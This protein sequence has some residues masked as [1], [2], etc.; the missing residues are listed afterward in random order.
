MKIKRS[1]GVLAIFSIALVGC[2]GKEENSTEKQQEI[3][4]TVDQEM[5]TMNSVLA[6]DTY[7]IT[8]LNNVMEGLYRLTAEN[9][10]ELAGAKELPEI[11]ENQLIYKIE[12]NDQAKWSNGEPVTAEDYVYAW[13]KAVAPETAAEYSYLF[14][15]IE[16]ADDIIAGKKDSTTLGITAVDDENIEITLVKP[17]PYFSHLLAFPAFFPQN[18]KFVSEQGENYAKSSEHLIYNGPF[19]L[20]DFDGPGTDT[21]WTYLKNDHYW[22]KEKVQ[23]TKIKNQV[24]KES[25]T[26]VNL[27]EAKQVDD[28]LLTGELA[29]QYQASPEFVSIEKAGTT[30][31]SYNQTKKEFQNKNLR[32]AISL[33]IDRNAIVDQI[34]GDGSLA[35]TGIVPSGMSFN[36]KGGEDFAKQSGNHVKTDISEAKIAWDE[37]KKELGINELKIDLLAYD[38]DAIKKVAEYL[39]STIQDNLEGITVN[40]SV[41]P[42]SV[43]VERGKSAD[44]DL[45]LFGWTAD[46]ADPSSFLDLFTAES[47]YNY[48]KYTNPK[49]DELVSLASNQDITDL[50]KRWNDYISAEEI[51]LADYGIAPLIQKAEARLRNTELKNVIS[52]ST[53]AQFDYKTAYLSE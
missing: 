46:Y 41:V 4:V 47:V 8:A 43:A 33:V 7:S 18:E 14:S 20:A 39:Q 28:I 12:L 30:Y 1:L 9:E 35:P 10:L 6:S 5:S 53:G 24:S 31:L 44:F 25:A 40:V 37:A 2:V 50:E 45:F 51:L 49:Y 48:G 13:R 26:N 29:K 38:T 16:N 52:H 36:P 27:F 21:E 17:T 32:K 22:D 11:D 19:I 3:T 34:L 15:S 23:L 42:V